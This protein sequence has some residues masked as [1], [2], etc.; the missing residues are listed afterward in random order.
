MWVFVHYHMICNSVQFHS[1]FS[2]F[3]FHPLF[4]HFFIVMSLSLWYIMR[5][6]TYKKKINKHFLEWFFS[7]NKISKF[8][9][10]IKTMFFSLHFFPIGLFLWKFF[11][12]QDYVSSFWNIFYRK[13]SIWCFTEFFFSLFYILKDFT[14]HLCIF[15]IQIFMKIICHHMNQ[16]ST[17][18]WFIISPE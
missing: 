7:R 13:T 11:C 16:K 4:P 5:N 12:F 15:Y 9:K 3:S 14:T 8:W 1:H 18:F 10:M 6:G 2:K 17:I